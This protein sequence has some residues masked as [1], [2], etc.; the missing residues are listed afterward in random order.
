MPDDFGQ[1]L[2]RRVQEANARRMAQ[3]ILR[4]Q[5]EDPNWK[6]PKDATRKLALWLLALV[7]T[8]VAL[9][10]LLR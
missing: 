3:E 7:L 2:V 10:Y 4:K 6:P 1:L 5:R 8:V 9:T